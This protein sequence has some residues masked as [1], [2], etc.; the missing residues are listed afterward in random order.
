MKLYYETKIWKEFVN[1]SEAEIDI[2]ISYRPLQI[3]DVSGWTLIIGSS[4]G[5][6]FE[7]ISII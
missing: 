6:T 5:Y 3:K 4:G 2:I 1:L 7:L